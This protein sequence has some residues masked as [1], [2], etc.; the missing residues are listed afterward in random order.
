LQA[1]APYF[2]FPLDDKLELNGELAAGGE[3]GLG[4]LHV[5]EHLPLVVGRAAGVHIAVPLGGSEWR[6]D[7]LV[8]R[9]GGLYVVVTVNEHDRRA[10]NGR[11]LRVDNR[12]T[13]GLDQPWT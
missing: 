7:P 3:P 5:G 12:V 10:G 4:T 2:L 1:L 11:R 13:R 9:I 8:E 6:R